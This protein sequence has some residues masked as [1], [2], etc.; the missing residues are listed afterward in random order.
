MKRS[1]LAIVAASASVAVFF[2]AGAS[3]AAARDVIVVKPGESIQAAVDAARPGTTIVVRRGTY[4]ENVAITT[5]A[6]TLRGKGATLV[7]PAQPIPNACSFGE[8]ANDGICVI[9]ELDV[10]DPDAPPVVVDPVSDVTISGFVVSGFPADGIFFFGAEDPVVFGNRLRD[11]GEYG[12]FHLFSAGGRIA[13][14]RA[15][16]SGVAG[17][18]VGGSPDA[19]VL[20]YG[21]ESFDNDLFGFFLRDAGNGRVVA[22]RAYGNCV[23]ALVLNTGE[24]TAR[25]WRFVGNRVTDNDKFCPGEPDGFPPLSGIGIGIAGGS[26]NRLVGNVIRDNNPSGEVPFSGG[27]VVV[28]IGIPGAEL[29]S[30]NRVVGNVILDNDPD[31][32]W[33]G[34]GDGNVFRANLCETSVPEGLC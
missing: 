16:G 18:Y 29:P 24:N 4:A 32:F 22:N 9:G 19:D 26:D 23:G 5:D 1:V 6:L 34:T 10:S 17:I 15:S 8:P 3:P 30:G 13:A 33:D 21:N 31:I 20:I 28:D 11:N 27:V 14:N 25:D 7:P 2:F 12:I